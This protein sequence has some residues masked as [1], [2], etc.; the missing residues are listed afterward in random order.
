MATRALSSAINMFQNIDFQKSFKFIVTFNEMPKSSKT[1]DAYNCGFRDHLV[2]NVSLPKFAF[3]KEVIEYGH[4]GEAYPSFKF[5]GLNLVITMIEDDMHNTSKF[6][7]NIYDCQINRETGNIINP[8]SAY[9]PSIKIEL[10]DNDDEII[11]TYTYRN[12]FL[13]DVSPMEL[14]Y[15][16]SAVVE[17]RLEFICN[18]YEME[19]NREGTNGSAYD[20][21]ELPPVPPPQKHPKKNKTRH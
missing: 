10:L 17:Y 4:L 5:E 8:S 3:S 19:L 6:I 20:Q 12:C 2:K 14:D 15:T 16:Q 9:I 21:R 7:E 11:S 18:S 13:L 1:K